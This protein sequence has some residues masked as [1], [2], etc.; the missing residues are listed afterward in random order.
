MRR[1]TFYLYEFT[2]K[3]QQLA[4]NIIVTR[5]LASNIIVTQ[6]LASSIEMIETHVGLTVGAIPNAC[7]FAFNQM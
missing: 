1:S 5:A 6:V 4:S 3:A 2:L 7:T